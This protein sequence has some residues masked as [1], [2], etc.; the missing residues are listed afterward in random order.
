MV[1][2]MDENVGRILDYLKTSGRDNNTIVVLMSDNGGLSTNSKSSKGGPTS[3][4]PLRA[5]KAW[6]YE[7][8]I[9][10]PMIIRWPGTT[11]KGSVCEVPVISTDFYPTILDM[12]GLPLKPNQ[13]LDGLS[14]AGLLRGETDSLDRDALYFHF[15]HDHAVNSMGASGAVRM[16]DYKLV[17]RFKNMDVELFNLRDDLGEQNDLSKTNPK[18]AAKLTQM[19]HDWRVKTGAR[20]PTVTP[21]DNEGRGSS[22]R[23]QRKST[24][25][26]K[27]TRAT[28]RNPM[29]ENKPI[30]ISCE[31]VPGA[32]PDG[33]LVAQGGKAYGYSVYVQNGKPCFSVRVER[34]LTTVVSATAAPGSSF[35]T[36]AAL[37]E[38]GAMVLR[39][40]GAEVASGNAGGLITTQPGVGFSIGQ[41]THTPVGL[42]ELPFAY[43]GKVSEVIVNGVNMA[44]KFHTPKQDMEGLRANAEHNPEL[45]NV[46]LIGDSI[47]IGYTKPTIQMLKNTANVQRA[48][49]NCGDTNSGLRGL[50]RWLGKTRWDVI[51]F[52]WGLHDL[53]YRHPDSKV[54][55]RR[56]KANGTQAVPLDQYGK[57]LDELV[58]QLK[59]TGAKLIWASTTAVPE[60]EAGRV[61]GDDIKYNEVAAGIMKKH[62]VAI[63]DLHALSASFN[64]THSTAPGNV[65]FTKE[66]SVKLAEQVVKSVREAMLN[67][68]LD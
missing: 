18:L 57:N 45:P 35:R 48:P 53:C 66:G 63:N 5:G 28:G 8:G 1:E 50:K 12:A 31:A 13:H 3:N 38:G 29:V 60:G 27:A 58:Q 21:D 10:E 52:N 24:E 51:H 15:P 59:R 37:G 43:P 64:G 44:T 26:G 22:A 34:K 68:P 9:R 25:R 56:D 40:N 16:G 47:S 23:Q 4:A 20:M 42:Y 32:E 55:G 14:L 65:H 54:Q 2:S 11:Q 17:E 62:G 30:T 6:V 46:L 7:G 67:A 36:E 19:L 61:L 41:D 39:L 33:V 49:T